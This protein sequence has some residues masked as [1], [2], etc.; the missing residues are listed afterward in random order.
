MGGDYLLRVKV[1]LTG[2]DWIA[3]TKDQKI[4]AISRNWGPIITTFTA[5]LLGITA[6]GFY[7]SRSKKKWTDLKPAILY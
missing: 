1:K 2:T 7:F 6:L 3:V 4:N 5:S